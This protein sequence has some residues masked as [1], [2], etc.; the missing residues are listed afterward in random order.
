[1]GV[2]ALGEHAGGGEDVEVVGVDV[3]EVVPAQRHRHRRPGRAAHRPGRG[4][5]AVAGGLVVVEEHALAALLLPPV[6]GGLG[7]DAPAHLAGQGDRPRAGRRRSPTRGAPAPSRGCR[8]RPRSSGGPCRPASSSTSRSTPATRTASAKSVPGWG[9]RSMRS[10][11]GSST[12]PRRTGQGWKSKV[13]R[14]AAH[15]GAAVTRRA[16]LLG[17]AAAGEAHLHRLEPRRGALGHA[18]LVEELAGHAVDEALEVGRPLVEHGEQRLADR[19]VVLHDLALGDAAVREV[20]LVGVADAHGDAVDV[21]LLRRGLRHPRKVRGL[22]PAG[23]AALVGGAQPVGQDLQLPAQPDR[24]PR[25]GAPSR[26]ARAA[27]RPS[28]GRGGPG[29]RGCRRPRRCARPRAAAAHDTPA[30]L[31]TLQQRRERATVEVQL[32][33]E[34]CPSS[35]ARAPRAPAGRRTGCRSDRVVRGP[36]GRTPRS[37]A[38]RRATRSTAARRASCTPRCPWSCLTG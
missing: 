16:D 38:R 18:L 25:S 34:P 17:G 31:E 29:R 24:G 36:C 1:M 9:S 22:L 37:H 28:P 7:G 4:D 23:H 8:A 19:D 6:H 3:G 10:S 33:A 13:P 11:S 27:G 30:L 32:A 5:R 35:P 20:D 26:P 14:L 2:A 12:R 21:D 15:T